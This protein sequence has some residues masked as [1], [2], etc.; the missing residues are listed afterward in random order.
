MENLDFGITVT[1]VGMAT[2]FTTLV[3]LGFVVD[4]LKKLF[5]VEQPARAK[6]P[7]PLRQATESS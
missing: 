3:F 1:I 5:P 6:K 2:T 4:L 7:A